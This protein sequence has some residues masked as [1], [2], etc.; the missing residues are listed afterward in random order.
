M[1]I[2]GLGSGNMQRL[3]DALAAKGRKVEDIELGLFGA[4]A[5]YDQLQGRLEQGFDELVF[6]LPP[7]P[8][9]TVLPI[10]DNLAELVTK[11]R[12]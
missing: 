5:D 2:G 12:G 10:L 4:P 11:I 1:P 8:A 3:T 9:D 6:G 7:A